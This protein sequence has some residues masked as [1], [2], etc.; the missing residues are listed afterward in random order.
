MQQPV[1]KL[2]TPR[3]ALL[4]PSGAASWCFHGALHAVQPHRQL[5]SALCMPSWRKGAPLGAGPSSAFGQLDCRNV[6]LNTE[7][8]PS[9]GTVRP[10]IFL[11]PCAVTQ[12]NASFLYRGACL[13]I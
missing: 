10:S 9:A 1:Q 12:S 2:R 11:S 5:T 4:V 8:N 6:A 7:L 13:F 3:P